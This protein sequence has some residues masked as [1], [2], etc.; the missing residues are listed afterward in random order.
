[1]NHLEIRRRRL[2]ERGTGLIGTLV[3][4]VI[5][6]MFLF[7]SMHL[8]LH[9]Y[10]TSLVSSAAHDAAAAVASAPEATRAAASADAQAALIGDLGRF[11]REM[12]VAWSYAD[13]RVTVTITGRAPSLLP[14][15][16][17]SAVGLDIDE[18]VTV[19]IEKFRATEAP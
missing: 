2:H 1:V 12:S 15:G 7:L 8:L 14:T 10:A 16:L 11:G 4:F 18:T 6:L 5:F 17:T 13:D 19:R 9:L 3:G